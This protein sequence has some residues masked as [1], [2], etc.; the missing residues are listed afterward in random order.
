MLLFVY[1]RGFCTSKS[2]LVFVFYFEVVK[3]QIS[4]KNMSRVKITTIAYIVKKS[5]AFF[6]A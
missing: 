4:G 2:S 3:R 1:D 5:S 6:M